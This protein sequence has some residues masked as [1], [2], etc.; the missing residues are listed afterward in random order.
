MEKL[1]CMS[2][3]T[4]EL[5][6]INASVTMCQY[7]DKSHLACLRGCYI[8]FDRILRIS[9]LQKKQLTLLRF[10]FFFLV[11]TNSIFDFMLLVN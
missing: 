6:F 1:L 2:Y 9:Y 8:K 10:Y 5:S 4:V 7:F 11:F 3:M